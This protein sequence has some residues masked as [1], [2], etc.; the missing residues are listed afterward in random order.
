MLILPYFTHFWG[1]N[2]EPDIQCKVFD[3][4]N[5]CAGL[6]SILETGI[7]VCTAPF[8]NTRWSIYV[9][10][11]CKCISRIILEHIRKIICFIECMRKAV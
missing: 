8:Y 6:F 2:C 5:V 9:N 7:V 4:L 1:K 11:D 10:R 3:I